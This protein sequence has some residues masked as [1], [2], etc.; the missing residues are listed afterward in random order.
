[1]TRVRNRLRY[2]PIGLVV[3]ALAAPAA[4][5]AA[6]SAQAAFPGANGKIAYRNGVD[7]FTINADGSD[8][9]NLTPIAGQDEDPEYSPDGKRI[10]FTSD[11]DGGLPQLYVM[12]AD[13]SAQ[14][15]IAF[16]AFFDRQPSFSPDGLRLAYVTTFE[17]PSGDIYTVGS[18]GGGKLTRLTDDAAGSEHP[19][20]SPD[21][22]KIAFSSFREGHVALAEAGE[23][24]LRAVRREHRVLASSRVIGQPRQLAAAV[25]TDG[26]DVAAGVLERGDVREPE[27]IRRE[28][29]LPVKERGER[30]PGLRG[31]VGVHDIQLREAAVAVAREG[32]PLPIRRVLGVLVLPC[33]RR[34]VRPVR[35]V[36][37]DR[38]HIDSVAV[39]D[40]A[41]GAGKRGLRRRRGEARRGRR[42]C[43]HD[44]TDRPVSK[45]IPYARHETDPL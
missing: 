20:F 7:V 33:D 37:V 45:T 29:G 18:D 17:N 27:P 10:A 41:V 3:L 1:M 32:D 14:T 13:G 15:R 25:G 26:V 12:N 11:R 2:R 24:D 23:R 31:T 22:T 44:E 6:A 43:E 8:R 19:V 42:E 28:R 5:F 4:G 16:S 9:T 34:Q 38:E 36:R 35:P 21:G 40:L 39:R 30:D